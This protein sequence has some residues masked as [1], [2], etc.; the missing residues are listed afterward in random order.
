[1]NKAMISFPCILKS[2]RCQTYETSEPYKYRLL[3]CRLHTHRNHLSFT[4]LH[5]LLL[6]SPELSKLVGE[7]EPAAGTSH[8]TPSSVSIN[9]PPSLL[10][11]TALVILAGEGDR[12]TPESP[13]TSHRR[14]PWNSPEKTTRPGNSL[15][16][17]LGTILIFSFQEIR[18]A[19]QGEYT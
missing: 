13:V 18:N 6:L 19:L 4:P 5:C 3:H 14:S 1:M 2:N 11:G 10:A 12:R 16:H 7:D 15:V 9:N 17:T 8:L